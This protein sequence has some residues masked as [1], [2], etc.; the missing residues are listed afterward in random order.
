MSKDEKIEKI[1]CLS[2]IKDY[3]YEGYKIIKSPFLK[4]RF[5]LIPDLK[6]IF[7]R[8]VFPLLYLLLGPVI[9][10]ILNKKFFNFLKKNNEFFKEFQVNIIGGN[11]SFI[12]K[13]ITYIISGLFIWVYT[14]VILFVNIKELL[15]GMLF[16]SDTYWGELKNSIDKYGYL[17]KKFNNDY[18]EVYKI[19]EKKYELLDGNHRYKLLLDKYGKQ[20]QLKVILLE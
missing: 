7:K 1:I 4:D 3:R 9:S 16:Y 19:N 5:L 10:L 6:I 15:G 8:V 20:Y 18:L 11:I 17:P 2:D 13:K 12:I 14:P